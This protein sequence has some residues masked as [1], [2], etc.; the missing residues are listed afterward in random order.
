MTTRR[1]AARRRAGISAHASG[2]L[3][4]QD[5]TTVRSIPCTTVARTLL[6][7]ADVIRPGALERALER[8]EMLR[9]LDT[10]AVEEQLANADGRRGAPTLARLIS[11]IRPETHTR[12]EFED[13]FLSL[14]CAA[15]IPRPKVNA[16]LA[17]GDKLMEAD[18]LWPNERLI[19]ES[20]GYAAH[21]T[22]RAFERDRRRDALLLVAGYRTVRVTWGQ[23]RN[24]SA[25]VAATVAAL[26]RSE[27][28][29]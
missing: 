14:C 9:V 26:F 28:R 1:G 17:L 20:D 24:A 13:R 19:V 12:S 10:R 25:E 3:R 15:G 29:E 2:T 22:R 18:F 21:G 6:D 4:P 5:V 27:K 7:L 23:L 16:Q 8:A 11:E